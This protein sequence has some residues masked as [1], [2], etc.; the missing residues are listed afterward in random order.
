MTHRIQ[1]RE[2]EL[3][4]W[5][6]PRRPTYRH[7]FILDEFTSYGFMSWS[8]GWFELRKWGYPEAAQ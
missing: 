6:L 7:R 4:F 1:I 8:N 3:I 2:W 5:G